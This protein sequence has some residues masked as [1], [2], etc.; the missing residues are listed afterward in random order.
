MKRFLIAGAV[1]F[2]II[3]LGLAIFDPSLKSVANIDFP[4]S[5]DEPDMPDFAKI[6]SDFTKED[7]MTRRAE[8]AGLLRGVDKEH[9]ADPQKR[10]E[11]VRQLEEQEATLAARS[12]SPEKTS[13]LAAWTAIGPAPIP[14]GQTVGVTT[15][16]SGRTTA[17][18]VHPMNPDIVYVGTA[19]GGLY[20]ST[21]GGT[22]WTPLLDNALSLAIG[23]VAIAPSQ[24]DTVYVGTGEPNFSS[25]S[26]FGVGVYRI[27][28][29]STSVPTVVGPLNQISAMP[30]TD[31]FTGRGI[32]EIIVHPTDPST[33]FVGSTSGVGGI[34]GGGSTTVPAPSRGVYRSTNATSAN[35]TFTKLT[36]LEGGGNFSI[37][38]M[39]IDPLNPNLMVVNLI[40]NGGGIYVS[41]DALAASPTFIRRVTFASGDTNE[42]TAEFAIQH[43]A[44]QPN[45]TIY[46][47]TGN[48]G[49]RVLRS[50]DGG[51]T[52]TQQIDNNFCT[53]Q[54]FYDIAVDVDPTNPDRLYIGGAPNVPFAFSIT[55]GTAFTTSS[56]GLHVDSHAIAVAPS[57][58]STLYFGSDG[59]IYKSTNSGLTFTVLNNTQFSATQFMGLDVHPTDSN[60]TLG[61]TQ[62]NG[63]SIRQASG[64][65][66][67]T[68]FGDGGYSVID[69]N[70]VNTTNVRMYHTYFNAQT[71][72]GYATQSNSAAF[73]NWTFRGCQASG[74]TT[75]GITCNVG[76]TVLF[77]APLERGPGNP[78]TTYYG[79][80]RLYRSTDTG[81][82]HTVV[83]QNPITAGVAISA[84][85]IA[86]QDD[87]V[88]IV[89]QTNGG[90]FGTTTGSATLTSLDP[91]GAG[92]VIPD[93][94]VARA[95]IAPNSTT[96]AYV[97]LAAFGTNNVFK[98]TNLNAATPTWT[99]AVGTG[100]NTLPQVPVSS[101]LID[102]LI[103]NNLYAGTDIG[104]YA[105][106]DG[107]ANWSP[108]GTG[109]PRIA[110]FG[111]E[112]APGSIVRAA[113]HG[114]GM[115]QIPAL[116][117]PTAASATVEGIVVLPIR[118]RRIFRAEVTLTDMDGNVRSITANQ[119][120][121]FRFGEVETGRI[122]ILNASYKGL[123]STPQAISVSQD[124]SGIILTPTQ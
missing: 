47:A 65:W 16:V 35:A 89:G 114:K 73:E 82:T 85:G 19:Q 31:I 4:Y 30:A 102:P 64:T 12:E 124:V 67:R 21:D 99:A 123:T 6:K 103:P 92:G 61:G 52:F 37:R 39:A 111:L 56:T 7:F 27:D 79:S 22:N 108:F 118:T 66:N 50:I 80:D 17:I 110:V 112:M 59:G 121:N 104:V 49:G 33:I 25:D 62:D 46:A 68:D 115:Y 72:Q 116:L 91:I 55:G 75:N 2:M 23:A 119:S 57:L 86:P 51:T 84:I 13:L 11:G 10:I 109:L 20:R 41:T 117:A 34:N 5:G 96:T 107:G 9:P 58:P 54:C 74:V 94:F 18:A 28:N 83:S 26:F 105:S 63:T 53:P 88:R 3:G 98:T 120:G 29:A 44:G 71:L 60:Y 93:R 113:T 100:A 69:Q 43:T 15:P 40:A 42:L 78:N 70:A 24:P 1:I 36:G 8:G 101:F 90:L 106:T 38:D 87:N 81:L 76:S 32:G 48:G 97:T 45:P 77:Y 14:N 95:V 122:Y